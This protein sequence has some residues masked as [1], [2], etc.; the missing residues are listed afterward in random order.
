MRRL[1][2]VLVGVTALVA[3]GAIWMYAQQKPA[4]GTLSPQEL[5]RHLP[6]LRILHARRRTRIAEK[7][8][9]A[10]H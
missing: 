1:T 6:T 3:G 7:R 2:I 9:V 8:R 5:H 4:A 10:V